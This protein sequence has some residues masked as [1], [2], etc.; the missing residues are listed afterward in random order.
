MVQTVC[1]DNLVMTRLPQ[2]DDLSRHSQCP[3]WKRNMWQLSPGA[4]QRGMQ[5]LHGDR[6]CEFKCVGKTAATAGHGRQQA[7]SQGTSSRSTPMPWDAAMSITRLC[8]WTI[9]I[10]ITPARQQWGLKAPLVCR[11]WGFGCPPAQ[12]SRLPTRCERDCR[13]SVATVACFPQDCEEDYCYAV[14]RGEASG[15]EQEAIREVR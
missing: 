6:S 10:C 2:G 3:L 8:T 1:N 15:A 7:C 12:P 13:Q 11:A 9:R 5:G 4:I 14:A